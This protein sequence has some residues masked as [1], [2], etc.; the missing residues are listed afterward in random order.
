MVCTE[1][2]NKFNLRKPSTKSGQ[3]DE[4]GRSEVWKEGPQEEMESVQMS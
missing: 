2:A 3:E 1:R 4:E